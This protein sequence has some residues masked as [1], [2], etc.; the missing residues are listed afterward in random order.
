VRI[1][2]TCM[3]CQTEGVSPTEFIAA[4]LENSGLYRM[5]C[6]QRN[7]ETVTCLQA[8]KF[9]VLFDLAT[10]AIVDGYYRDAVSS[11][12]SSLERFFEFCIGVICDKQGVDMAALEAAWKH[13][14]SQSERQIGA[15]IFSYLLS[16]KTPPKLL[17]QKNTEFRNDVIHK[18]RIPSR[19]EAIQFGEA[20]AEVI[21]RTLSDLRSND[22]TYIQAAVQRYVTEL[23]KKVTV[24]DVALIAI[25]TFIGLTRPLTDAQPTL[26]EWIQML[27]DQRLRLKIA[28][29]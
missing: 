24:P 20:V 3:K 29:R 22:E 18:G 16:M 28:P 10:H 11:F 13:V 8:Q 23:H 25:G 21:T 15:Y 12:T 6:G 1:Y 26:R 4:E 27:R 14:S 5:V 19:E 17:S 2:L 9:E 7:H